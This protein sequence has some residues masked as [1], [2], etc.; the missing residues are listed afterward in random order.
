MDR[1]RFVTSYQNKFFFIAI[2][3]RVAIPK[4]CN[5]L[6]YYCN[7][8]LLDPTLGT[9]PPPLEVNKIGSSVKKLASVSTRVLVSHTERWRA[10]KLKSNFLVEEVVE[11]ELTEGG[12]I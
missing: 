3:K 8:I 12:E 4:Y 7:T 5:N 6:Q 1:L 2:V 10:C 9:I 11:M